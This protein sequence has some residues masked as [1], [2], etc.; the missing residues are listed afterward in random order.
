M[1]RIIVNGNIM[2]LSYIQGIQKKEKAN[3]DE[4]EWTLMVCKIRSMWYIRT[5]S[6]IH[7]GG[8]LNNLDW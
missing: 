6:K 4:K 1:R 2:L 5:N 8:F 7:Q 3:R